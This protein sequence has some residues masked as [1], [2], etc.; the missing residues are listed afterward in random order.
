MA[1]PLMVCLGVLFPQ[2]FAAA[3]SGLV[4]DW[5]VEAQVMGITALRTLFSFGFILGTALA[6]W[7]SGFI[8][9]QTIYFLLAFGSLAVTL[10]TA[11]A[12]YRIDA[13]ITRQALQ[14][15]ETGDAPTAP[16]PGI[17]ISPAALVIPLLALL[18]LVGADNTRQ[19]YISLVMFQ[20]FKDASISPTMFGITAAFELITMGLLG[21]FASRW[22]ERLVIAA[23][24]LSAA[25]Y[26]VVMASSQ[27]LPLLYLFQ[28]EYAIF[29][30]A[31]YGVAMAYVQNL[32]SNRAGLGGSLYVVVLNTGS[33]VGILAPLLITGYDQKIFYIPAVLCVVGALMLTAAHSTA[34]IRKRHAA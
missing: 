11:R 22:D 20:T 10:F 30:A 6:G 25:L 7:M 15:A 31:L 3:K 16:P 18:V 9:L 13:Q 28:A 23:A 26:Y 17:A 2:M 34:R 33:L 24:A 19:T 1:A 12:L 32:L 8:Q 29:V 14:P 27:S 4:A 21:Y 5:E